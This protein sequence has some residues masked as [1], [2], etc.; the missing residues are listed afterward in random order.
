[1]SKRPGQDPQRRPTIGTTRNP[2]HAGPAEQVDV[3][4]V[5]FVSPQDWQFVSSSKQKCS[6]A[7]GEDDE[8]LVKAIV[9]RLRRDHFW[10]PAET[11]TVYTWKYLDYPVERIVFQGPG[12]NRLCVVCSQIGR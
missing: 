10:L 4:V 6:E 11:G 8:A 1:M 3:I 7:R 9:K 5:K 2:P 12:G